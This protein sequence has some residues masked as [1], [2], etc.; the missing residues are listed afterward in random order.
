MVRLG[1]ALA[2][3]S[4][5]FPAL[6]Q[7]EDAYTNTM[8][9]GMKTAVIIYTEK[10]T[11]KCPFERGIEKKAAFHLGVIKSKGLQFVALSPESLPPDASVLLMLQASDSKV[12]AQET[13]CEIFVKF[14]VFH[15]M[16]GKLRYSDAEPVLRVLAYRTFRAET[17]PVGKL[18]D[19]MQ[20]TAL[21]A[22][23]DFAVAY[24]AANR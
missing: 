7:A 22:L 2:A 13:L 16:P 15:L 21:R 23:A 1:L 3:L 14:E 24:E 18:S 17:A 5:A 8:L 19:V 12:E 9:R 11:P 4:A 10:D 20:G 6:V